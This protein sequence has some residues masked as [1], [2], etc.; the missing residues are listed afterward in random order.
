MDSAV[1]ACP[2][3]AHE[4]VPTA[5]AVHVPCC[6]DRIAELIPRRSSLDDEACGVAGHK[7]SHV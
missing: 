6:A 1:E 4:N 5:V 2:E 7:V 3:C